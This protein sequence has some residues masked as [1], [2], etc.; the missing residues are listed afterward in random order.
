[1]KF[2]ISIY[3]YMIRSIY[4]K[5]IMHMFHL[6]QSKF[7]SKIKCNQVSKIINIS[8]SKVSIRQT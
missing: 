8:F 2:Y 1:M 5:T 7:G 3:T 4:T 6:I